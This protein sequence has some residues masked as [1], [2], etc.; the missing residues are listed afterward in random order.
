MFITKNSQGIFS[1]GTDNPNDFSLPSCIQVQTGIHPVC[2]GTPKPPISMQQPQQETFF[3]LLDTVPSLVSRLLSS[4]I[5][6]LNS[7]I[8]NLWVLKTLKKTLFILARD[9][10]AFLFPQFSPF[11][12]PPR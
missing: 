7:Q 9:D 6:P 2:R 1:A 4:Y 11:S 12:Q 3:I 8:V 10:T 5:I